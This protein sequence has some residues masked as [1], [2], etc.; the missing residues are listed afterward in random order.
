MTD[1]DQR[2]AAGER[3]V[4]A[5]LPALLHRVR[6][7]TQLLV[8][9]R[10]LIE[11]DPNDVPARCSDDLAFAAQESA[12]HGW[13]MGLAAHALGADLLRARG[14][15]DG[16]EPL[17]TL[18]R[19]SLQRIDVRFEWTRE[20]LPKLGAGFAGAPAPAEVSLILASALWDSC[21]EL[22]A[23]SRVSLHVRRGIERHALEFAG[24]DFDAALRTAT[25]YSAS[26]PGL[27]IEPI[28]GGWRMTLPAGCLEFER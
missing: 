16:L 24:A 13:L 5:L 25:S 4:V 8:G 7:T 20:E 27:E 26:A 23:G 12:E 15:R 10:A 9:L 18:M 14:E 11:S 28:E 17:F 21:C 3:L 22:A 2:R 1:P 19:E 6:N